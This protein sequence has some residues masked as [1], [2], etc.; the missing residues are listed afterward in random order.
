MSEKTA[1]REEKKIHT[2]SGKEAERQQLQADTDA[3][4]KAGGE[5]EIVPGYDGY[6]YPIAKHPEP[7]SLDLSEDESAVL[8]FY[9]RQVFSVDEICKCTRMSRN[10]VQKARDG[11]ISRNVITKLMRGKYEI[12][13]RVAA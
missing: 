10:R 8:S 12:V 9:E 2:V 4:L 3:F 11:M 1:E 7:I 6:V 13:R 5:I